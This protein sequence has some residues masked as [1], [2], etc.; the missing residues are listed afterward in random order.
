MEA[1]IKRS[2][3]TDS[4]RTKFKAHREKLDKERE[5]MNLADPPHLSFIHNCVLDEFDDKKDKEDALKLINRARELYDAF[6]KDPV[7]LSES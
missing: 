5:R 6:L 2:R 7:T 4:M 1:D 3:K